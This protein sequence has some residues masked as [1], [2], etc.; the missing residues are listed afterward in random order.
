MPDVEYCD[1]V[2]RI[3]S[4]PGL[5]SEN[6]ELTRSRVRRVITWLTVMEPL[7]GASRGV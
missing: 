4:I 5:G 1:L 2:V 7:H 3:R 6:L